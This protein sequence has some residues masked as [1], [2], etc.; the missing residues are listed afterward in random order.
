[1]T[2]NWMFVM[3]GRQRVSSR[4]K[5]WVSVSTSL[6]KTGKDETPNT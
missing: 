5:L 6:G 1:M 4:S 2:V 3:K